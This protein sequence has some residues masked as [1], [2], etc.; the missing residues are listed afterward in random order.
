MTRVREYFSKYKE[1][2][3]DFQNTMGN[4]MKCTPL[5]RGAINIQREL[6]KSTNATNVLH[7]LGLG[8]NLIL[9]SQLQDKGYDIHF[10]GKKV[11]VKH[12]S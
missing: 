7:V 8:M 10:E 3:L 4:K 5:G 2:H 12:S 9:V 1:D 6:G 11:F